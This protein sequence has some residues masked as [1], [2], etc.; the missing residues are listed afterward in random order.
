MEFVEPEDEPNQFRDPLPPDD[1]LWRH[2]S[3]IGAGVPAGAGLGLPPASPD[4]PLDRAVAAAGDGD[5]RPSLWL[6]AA[7]SAVSAGLI[8]SG[9]AL[10]VVGLLGTNDQLRPAVERQMEPRPIDAV[11]TG[12]VAD[13]AARARA[14]VAQLRL[15]GASAAAGSGVIFR[16]DGHLLTSASVVGEATTVQVTLDNGR[17]VSGRVVGTDRATDVAVV[18]I[19]GAGPF[20]TAVLGRASDLQVGQQAVA[21]GWPV[22]LMGGP[23]VTVGVVSALHRAVRRGDG[24]M[25]FDMVQT[26]ARVPTGWP[27]GALLDS[28]GSV[29]GIT[30]A[31]GTTT[32]D[33]VAASATGT[34]TG[35][36]GFAVPI[37]LARSVA[38]QLIA[39]GRVTGVWLG[40]Q[41]GDL[42][43][44]D[45]S[46]LE[47]AGGAVV[48]EVKSASPAERAG[49]AAGDV[50]V[51]L[52]G[53]AVTS[54]GHLVV[55]LR[56]HGP[57][58]AVRLDV[59]RDQQRMSMTVVLVERPAP[60]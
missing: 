4:G 59:M 3:E 35:G 39:N 40:V 5:A 10:V 25:L 24:G 21:I 46:G 36:F 58:D 43:W 11:T 56:Q 15:A 60:A 42:D 6:V 19:D 54:M 26:D 1:R 38:D 14:A 18:K 50:I 20:P 28:S 27:G 53:Q 47:V 22:G 8:A 33:T 13:V 2:P 52:D 23:S 49:L 31:V 12:S 29:I 44:V 34:A 32:T 16:S 45:A 41:G 55:A 57:G 37:D 48:G 7:V 51:G 9:L 17:Q 30:T